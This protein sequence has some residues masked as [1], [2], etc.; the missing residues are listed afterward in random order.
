MT[1]LYLQSSTCFFHEI[2]RL[3][4]ES[5]KPSVPTISFGKVFHRS[6]YNCTSLGVFWTQLFFVPVNRFL[7]L[8]RTSKWT[9]RPSV[10]TIILKILEKY[11]DPNTNNTANEKICTKSHSHCSD[12]NKI[13]CSLSSFTKDHSTM[14]WYNL[15]VLETTKMEQKNIC[16]IPKVLREYSGTWS[17]HLF[18]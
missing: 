11:Y 12:I 16:G 2:N 13:W 8:Y 14:D 18:L 5:C 9:P 7:H 6:I 1:S 17:A 15:K 3:S 4:L 10:L